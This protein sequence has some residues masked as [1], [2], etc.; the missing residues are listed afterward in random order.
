MTN[1]KTVPPR[2]K[3]T[4]RTCN[5][6]K[7][8]SNHKWPEIL[9]LRPHSAPTA[10]NNAAL[11]TAMNSTLPKSLRS[12]PQARLNGALT[13]RK[14]TSYCKECWHSDKWTPET[15]AVT[16]ISLGPFSNNLTN[17]A[18]AHRSSRSS[19]TAP[20]SIVTTCISP[21]LRKLLSHHAR[22]PLRRLHVW[23]RFQA[24]HL[25]HGWLLQS[26]FELCY[27]CIDVHRCYGLKASQDC[28][29]CNSSTFLRDCIGCQDCFLCVGLRNKKYCFENGNSVRKNTKQ[30]DKSI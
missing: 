26:S 23:L 17:S 6:R 22:R 28:I 10:V 2:S 19:L 1:C 12:L 21:V 3:S 24:R 18:A 11:H 15:T 29:N 5:L 4:T 7:S 30:K 25:L 20:T 8:F 9:L 27:D 13:F 16:S 14:R